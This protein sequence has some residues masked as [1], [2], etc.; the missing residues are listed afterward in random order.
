MAVLVDG[1]RGDLVADESGAYQ[2]RSKEELANF[3]DL[4]K[5]AVG[6]A[7]ARGDS[8]EVLNIPFDKDLLEEA[9]QEPGA[10]SIY[11]GHAMAPLFIRY[12]TILII[13]V[14]V[15]FILVRPL[16]VW[17]LSYEPSQDL[18]SPTPGASGGG[19]ARARASRKSGS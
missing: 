8:I 9:E 16:I 2:A 11:S 14:L 5:S 17:L 13:S 12:A 18:A 6:F 4:A 10:I 19:R 7:E 15:L 1:I 3:T